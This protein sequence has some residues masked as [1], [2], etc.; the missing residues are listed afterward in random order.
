MERMGKKNNTTQKKE[1]VKI[2][3]S[4]KRSDGTPLISQSIRDDKRFKKHWN[5]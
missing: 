2:L 3:L 1:F 4:K 5:A